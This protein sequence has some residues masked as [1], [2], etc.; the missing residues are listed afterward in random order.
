M[1]N[2][3]AKLIFVFALLSWN[4][5]EAVICELDLFQNGQITQVHL[6]F[7][8]YERQ[9]DDNFTMI[10]Q[11]GYKVYDVERDWCEVAV[12]GPVRPCIAVAVTDGQ[13]V[14]VF[15]KHSTNSLEHMGSI[16]AKHLDLSDSSNLYGRI[17]T[18][19]DDVEWQMS[20]RSCMHANKT[21]AQAVLDTKNTLEELGFQRS[22]VPATLFNL[23]AN[24][25]LNYADDALGYFEYAE[26]TTCLALK[27]LFVQKDEKKCLQFFSTDFVK[28]DVFGYKGTMI[29][30]RELAGKQMGGAS[31]T[32]REHLAYSPEKKIPYNNIPDLYFKQTGM[33]DGYRVQ[34][35][36]VMR[37]MDSQNDEYYMRHFG[38]KQKDLFKTSGSYDT[39][40][41]FEIDGNL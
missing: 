15:H 33:N 12:I 41:F 19:R 2:I 31:P 38:K 1:K 21:H 35:G 40:E 7:A 5:A 32:T 24:G 4:T 30:Q 13:K 14:V 27:N 9:P 26:V 25:E 8:Y 22:N 23:R 6:P 10:H 18:T 34:R 20:R 28:E 3:F 37:F 16:I 36:V 17:F 39:L 11:G 29:S